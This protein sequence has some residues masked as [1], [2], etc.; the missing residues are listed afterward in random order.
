VIAE[1]LTGLCA[2]IGDDPEREGLRGTP[3]RVEKSW[4]EL[5]RGYKQDPGEILSR[6]FK[7]DGYDNMVVLRDVQFFSTCEHH[8]LPFHGAAHVAYLPGDEVVGLS[9]LARLVDCYS[10]RLQIQ[11]RMTTQIGKALEELLKVRGCGVIVEA[12]HLCMV[13]RGVQK[14][15]AVM[16]TCFLGGAFKDAAVR[17]EFF[18][19]VRKR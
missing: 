4:D 11:E 3:S 14:Q 18:E 13:S 17:A 5:Y 16:T 2:T 9:K 10:R 19:H 1:Y 8:L 12:Q 7:N 15:E 6:R